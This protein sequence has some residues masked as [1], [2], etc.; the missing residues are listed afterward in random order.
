MKSIKIFV[1]TVFL[2]AAFQAFA[3]NYE[4]GKVTVQELEEKEHPIE[5]DAA[6]AVLFESG[7][8]H[9]YYS[10]TDRNDN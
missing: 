1:I 2:L 7:K 4:L 5:K 9:F 10:A 8:T 6:A 3:Q